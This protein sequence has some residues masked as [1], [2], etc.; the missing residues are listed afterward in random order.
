MKSF[1]CP[2]KE[3]EAWRKVNIHL[4][5]LSVSRESVSFH[6]YDARLCECVRVD[7][8]GSHFSGVSLKRIDCSSATNKE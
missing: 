5:L 6:D 8:H 2:I 3:A 1:I 7:G 4:F